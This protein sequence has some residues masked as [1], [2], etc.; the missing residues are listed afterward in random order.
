MSSTFIT[1]RSTWPDGDVFV[2]RAGEWSEAFLVPDW[3]YLRAYDP[4]T[5]IARRVKEMGDR[6]QLFDR[7]VRED[8]DF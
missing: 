6:V 4:H 1:R 3:V 7:L 8:R 2:V 5:T